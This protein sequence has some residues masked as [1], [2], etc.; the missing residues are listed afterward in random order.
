[1]NDDNKLKSINRLFIYSAIVAGILFLRLIADYPTDIIDFSA[2]IVIIFEKIMI[3]LGIEDI[4]LIISKI[5]LVALVFASGIF[6][7]VIGLILLFIFKNTAEQGTMIMIK[8]PIKVIAIG[9]VVYIL[10]LILFFIFT[11][12]VIGLPVAIIIGILGY[13][14]S[15]LGG[16]SLAIFLGYNICNMLNVSGYTYMYYMIGSF[17]MV[18]CQS[19][20]AI[21]V[22]FS[23]YVFP[24]ISIGSFIILLLNKFVFK[25]SYKIEFNTK[26]EKEPFDRKKIKD[27]IT[28]GL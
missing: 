25:M 18:L 4:I 3:A 8:K 26:R 13:I 17:F 11:V 16:I 20:Y 7:V 21:G 24:V 2:G 28:K 23:M 1:M 9:N 22:A 15:F 27:I 14:I 5:P 10:G 12:S 6:K 19:V